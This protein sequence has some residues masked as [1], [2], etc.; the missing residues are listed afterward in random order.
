MALAGTP[1]LEVRPGRGSVAAGEAMSGRLL[2][3]EGAVEV[4]L[5]RRERSPVREHRTECVATV[6]RGRRTGRYVLEVPPDLPPT[7]AG[8]RCAIDYSITAKEPL[9]DGRRASAAVTLRADGRPHLETRSEFADRIVPNAPGRRFHLELAAADLRGGGRLSGRL[10][11]HRRWTRGPLTVELCSVESWRTPAPTLGAMPHWERDVLWSARTTVETD[12]D[13]TWVPFAFD[14][15]DDLPPAVEAHT[16]A[17]R[18]ELSAS[19]RTRIGI[20]EYALLTPVLFETG[21][22]PCAGA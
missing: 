3:F 10:H 17:W 6:L 5:V 19:R 9:G 12:P 4:A 21:A 7:A 16:L 14:I 2:G 1:G 22:G 8:R 20:D 18:Y 15:P 13:R 11:R